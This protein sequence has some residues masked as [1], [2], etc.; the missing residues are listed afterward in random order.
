MKGQL[1]ESQQAQKTADKEA[2]TMRMQHQEEIRAL[3]HL[4]RKQTKRVAGNARIAG[5]DTS[6]GCLQVSRAL[7]TA[8]RSHLLHELPTP[9]RR[10]PRIAVRFDT[11]RCTCDIVS[12]GQLSAAPQVCQ[13]QLQ[14]TQAAL[15]ACMRKLPADVCAAL[16]AQHSDAVTA[17]NT[18]GH[19]LL[20]PGSP[21]DLAVSQPAAQASNMS[22]ASP[23]QL[24]DGTAQSTPGGVRS[25]L[26]AAFGLSLQGGESGSARWLGTVSDSASDIP[27]ASKCAILDAVVFVLAPA[28]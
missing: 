20:S 7:C 24:S 19:A 18:S 12:V 15:Q 4:L 16:I 21:E 27:S 8:I 2:A 22:R 28:L 10:C 23:H 13:A 6:G 17:M 26:R 5:D 11:A 25:S 9:F 14:R 3:Q 1:F